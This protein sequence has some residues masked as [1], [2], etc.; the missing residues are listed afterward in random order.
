MS[1][2]QLLVDYLLRDVEAAIKNQSDTL[3]NIRVR[4][5]YILTLN[6]LVISLFGSDFL[7]R[8][9]TTENAFSQ[10]NI[11][12][13]GVLAILAAITSL[14]CCLK[15]LLPYNGW[16]FSH[17]PEVFL[18]EFVFTE[19][20]VNEFDVTTQVIFMRNDHYNTNKDK[21]SGFHSLFFFGVILAFLQILFWLIGEVL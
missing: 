20:D 5:S 3:Q 1:D 15:I 17:D 19:D 14:V 8:A 16:V 13:F 9:R 6:G 12:A 2:R 11:D 18:A 10:G 21:L 4:N 7:L